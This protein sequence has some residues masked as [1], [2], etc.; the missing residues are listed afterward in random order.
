[1]RRTPP[2]ISTSASLAKKLRRN[3]DRS[4][5]HRQAPARMP[6]ARF[7]REYWQ[8]RPLLVRGAFPR[9]ADPLTT[10]RS[11]R[12]RRR[13]AR[14]FAPCRAPPFARPL[15]NARRPVHRRRLRAAA[16]RRL[17][18]A[19]PGRGQVGR[20]CRRAARSLR[21]PAELAPRRCH[22]QLRGGTAARLERTSISTTCSSCRGADA[23]DGASARMSARRRI[24]ATTPRSG[25]CANSRR[26]TS[27]SWNRATCCICARRAASRCC[28]RRVPDVLRSAC[29][30]RRLLICW[31]ISPRR[32]R[33][34]CRKNYG[35]AIRILRRLRGDG[36]IDAAAFARVERAMPWLR[37]VGGG[38]ERKNRSANEG[39]MAVRGKSIRCCFVR[40][41]AVSS[42]AIAARMRRCRGRGRSRR[43]S[44]IAP[45]R[46]TPRAVRNPWSRAAWMRPRRVRT[47]SWPGPIRS[48]RFHLRG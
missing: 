30:R 16:E 31:W 44:S 26:R 43:R 18:A 29:G 21:L 42:R 32:S 12:S 3:R 23:G 6:T 8:K 17:D 11:R 2:G 5:R 35:C 41:S 47:C 19:R 28:D 9:F 40:G 20:R 45:S 48:V 34:R 4:P 46:S 39:L 14:A 25:C 1:M 38:V 10:E 15:A 7:L 37:L 13:G 27:G 22:G 24:F 36:E 33:R